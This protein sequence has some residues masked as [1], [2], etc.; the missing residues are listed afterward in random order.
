MMSEPD[1]RPFVSWPASVD[2]DADPER[3]IDDQEFYPLG[4]RLIIDGRV[5]DRVADRLKDAPPSQVN[6]TVERLVRSVI[7]EGVRRL[8][9][10]LTEAIMVVLRTREQDERYRVVPGDPTDP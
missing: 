9:R 4:D 5:Y 8:A 3:L 1:E 6:E 2:A 10:E 7:E